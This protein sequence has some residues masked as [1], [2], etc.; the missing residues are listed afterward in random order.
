M[1]TDLRSRGRTAQTPTYLWYRSA[2][3]DEGHLLRPPTPPT[4]LPAEPR[5]TT[6][7]LLP[8]VDALES[9]A[10]FQSP[11]AREE[12]L[13]LLR[14]RIYTA[15][16]RHQTTRLEA[17]SVIRTCLRFPGGLAELVEAVRFFA[18]GDPAM[19]RFA[20]A[21]RRLGVDP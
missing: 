10:E 9:V 21:A 17:V 1:F 14:G 8:A 7:D 3:G 13:R 16:P 11:P 18:A 4:A 15:I 6:D 2:T 19:E 12:I 5:P 20:A